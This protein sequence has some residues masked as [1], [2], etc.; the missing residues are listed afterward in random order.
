MKLAGVD[1]HGQAFPGHT[2][3]QFLKSSFVL[4]NDQIVRGTVRR[5]RTQI[6]IPSGLKSAGVYPL[7]RKPGSA[8]GVSNIYFM[9]TTK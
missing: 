1:L 7:S 9:V 5:Q 3:E 2:R 4:F 8:G 6:N